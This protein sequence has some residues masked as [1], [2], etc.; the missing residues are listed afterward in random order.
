M[1]IVDAHYITLSTENNYLAY[2]KTNA[3]GFEKSEYVLLGPELPY[4]IKILFN[5]WK[6]L[7]PCEYDIFPFQ[8][9]YGKILVGN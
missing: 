7:K 2:K 3:S 8:D 5:L 1:Y 4:D 6:I 9:G